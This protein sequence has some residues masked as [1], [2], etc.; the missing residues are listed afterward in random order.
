MS[1]K[2]ITSASRKNDYGDSGRPIGVR[3]TTNETASK[4][5]FGVMGNRPILFPL[6]PTHTDS[7]ILSNAVESVVAELKK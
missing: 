1:M 5:V 4:S 3:G 2:R 6:T 7:R